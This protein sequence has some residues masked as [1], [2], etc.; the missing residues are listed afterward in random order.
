MRLI[1]NSSLRRKEKVRIFEATFTSILLYGLDTLTLTPKQ[2]HRIDGQYYRSLRR[3]IG[4]EASYY[5][6]ISNQEVWTQASKPTLPSQTLSHRQYQLYIQVIQQPREDPT[7]NVI[8]GPAFKDRILL[9]GRRR[10]IKF[11]Y[12]VEVYSNRFFPDIKP[13]HTANPHGRYLKIA[14]LARS[15]SFELAPKRAFAE[16]AWP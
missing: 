12:W 16:R 7:H 2:L 5:S 13:D 10:G 8:F 3:A 14:K 6:H 9:K 1:W 4:I 11:P 15:R